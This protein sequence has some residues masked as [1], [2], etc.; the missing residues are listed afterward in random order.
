MANE[1]EKA[2]QNEVAVPEKELSRSELMKLYGI[3][4]VA[5]G[6]ESIGIQ[7][8]IVPRLYIA[9]KNSQKADDDMG[10]AKVPFGALYNSVTGEIYSRFDPNPDN[11]G[12]ILAVFL[13]A[14]IGRAQFTDDGKL[15]HRSLD[16]LRCDPSMPRRDGI[17]LCKNCPDSKFTTKDDGSPKKPVCP[18]GFT[19]LTIV[20]RGDGFDGPFLFTCKSTAWKPAL[21]LNTEVKMTGLPYYAFVYKIYTI[22]ETDP[23]V[24]WIPQFEKIARIQPDNE[25]FIAMKS[26]FEQYKGQRFDDAAEDGDTPF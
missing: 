11:N 15:K 26:M 20:K 16:T 25:F 1:V 2:K 18:E 14:D 7:H 3:E 4:G 21:K 17:T 6:T 8:V 22:K 13:K 5:E 19:Y 24:H 23:Q 10:D 9:Q 12:S